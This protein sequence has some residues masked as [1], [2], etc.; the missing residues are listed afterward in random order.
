MS[1]S[2]ILLDTNINNS[3]KESIIQQAHNLNNKNFKNLTNDLKNAS[4]NIYK[5]KK[6]LPH[7]TCGD[8][9]FTDIC[10]NKISINNALSKTLNDISNAQQGITTTQEANYNYLINYANNTLQNQINQELTNYYAKS[11]EKN[12]SEILKNIEK[13]AVNKLRMTEINEYYIKKNQLINKIIK[14][15]LVF[16][17]ILLIIIILVKKNILPSSVGYFFGIIIIIII[18]IYSL[19]NIYDIR[20]RDKLNFDEYIIPFNAEARAQESSGNF[21]DIGTELKDEFI[22]GIHDLETPLGCI[23]ESC[24]APGTIYDISMG[25]CSVQCPSGTVMKQNVDANG[26]IIYECLDSTTNYSM[27]VLSNIDS[28]SINKTNNLMGNN[29]DYSYIQNAVN[30]TRKS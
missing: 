26:K 14:Y 12:T 17:A 20:Q 9:S 23:G 18:V 27:N 21:I 10:G 4:F 11:Q 1:E 29:N 6:G 15:T 25:Q 22:K 19:Y 16:L 5:I 30:N 7:H 13:D 3:S 28:T 8:I 2:T 24:C